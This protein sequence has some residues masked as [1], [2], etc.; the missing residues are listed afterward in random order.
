MHTYAKEW[1]TDRST[2]V[3]RPVSERL[4]ISLG[5]SIFGNEG[6]SGWTF[7]YNLYLLM[8]NVNYLR[9]K[10]SNLYCYKR[11]YDCKK[12]PIRYLLM[13]STIDMF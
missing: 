5:H 6:P 11:K 9:L 2:G 12:W 4:N 3:Y 7:L 10:L 8:G 1:I 13:G